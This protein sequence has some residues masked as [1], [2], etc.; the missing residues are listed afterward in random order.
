MNI[1]RIPGIIFCLLFSFHLSAQQQES[2]TASLAQLWDK[3][4]VYNKKLK[5][6]RLALQ[7][8]KTKTD[9]LKDERLPEV[10]ANG[11]YER[12][13]S[14]PQ[15]EDGLFHSP[16]YYPIIHQAYALEAAASLNVY[17]GG[18]AQRNIR[19]N[20]IGED[21]AAQ[22]VNL[23]RSEI[24]Y[25]AAADYLDIY[26]NMRYKTLIE[27]DIKERLQQLKQ[28]ES[29]F[30]K[31][32]V[33]KSDVL[34]AQLNLSKQQ[35]L[36]TQVQNSITIANEALNQLTGDDKA[37][38]TIPVLNEDSSQIALIPLTDGYYHNATAHSYQYNILQKETE[39][40]KLQLQQV[41]SSILPKISLFA[42]YQY[43][44]PQIM[45]YPYAAAVYGFGMAGV[46]AS[47][48]LSE[49]YTN[50]QKRQYAQ[51]SIDRNQVETED[52]KDQLSVEISRLHIRYN[53]ALDR[54]NIAQQNI[55][56]ATET[57]RITHNSYFAQL[58]LLTDLLDA[59]T[60]LLQAKMDYTTENVNAQILYYQL[61][62]TIGNL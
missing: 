40:S 46:K 49:L 31:G 2:D 20:K 26:R 43:A 6:G 1:R 27:Q 47:I 60:Q 13:S 22:K 37:H 52:F 3:A 5:A 10:E 4:E 12:V 58:S 9:V 55:T 45:F 54:I 53:E 38:N 56:T 28:I 39:Q 8:V 29:L 50:K 32:V 41:K 42:Q 23:S 24:R 57:Y 33:L 62:K 51:I 18:T 21:I 35:E 7:Q 15:Y 59:E 34:R 48:S 30:S 25:Q 17:S 19:T 16:A 61:Q 14:M 36:L 44:Y 11:V